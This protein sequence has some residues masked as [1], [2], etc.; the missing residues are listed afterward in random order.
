MSSI[1][2]DNEL[3]N[4]DQ[5]LEKQIESGW[6]LE[7]DIDYN[8]KIEFSDDDDEDR[9]NQSANATTATTSTTKN[10]ETSDGKT[11]SELSLRTDDKSDSHVVRSR[12]SSSSS[13]KHDDP[14]TIDSNVKPYGPRQLGY[15]NNNN[16][17]NR[18]YGRKS[19]S[20]FEF[21][22]KDGDVSLLF[23]V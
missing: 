10:E 22:R 19:D 14:K 23:F 3:K 11:I 8:A 5:I 1:I 21:S 15:S 17:N 16:N 20:V 12:E 18:Y 13:N 7:E 9:L 4:L 2:T 6:T